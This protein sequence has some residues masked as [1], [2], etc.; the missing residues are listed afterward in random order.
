MGLLSQFR[1]YN[2]S[3]YEVTAEESLSNA[4]VKTIESAE[5]VASQEFEDSLS[6]LLHLKSGE[7]QYL[8]LSKKSELAEG[9][10]VDPKSIKI[11][12]LSAN[13]REDCH[14]ADGEAL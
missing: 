6:I 8:P 12:T 9:D 5:V 11:L 7:V 3:K 10:Q 4:E 13:G 1:T 2:K 14:K